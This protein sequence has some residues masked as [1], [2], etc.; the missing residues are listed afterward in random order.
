MTGQVLLQ[1]VE[2]DYFATVSSAKRTRQSD[3]IWAN[4]A[5]DWPSAST[6][7]PPLF[8][9]RLNLTSSGSGRDLGRFSDARVNARMSEISAMA[10]PA[11]REKAWGELD[12]GLLKRG[13]YVPLA[14][15]RGVFTAGSA[16]TGLAANEALGGWVDLARVGVR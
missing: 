6:V 8:D 16:V 2:K 4:W 7:L 12:R 9:S 1:P 3:V 13:V 15:Y 5:A 11:A 14:Q 10:D